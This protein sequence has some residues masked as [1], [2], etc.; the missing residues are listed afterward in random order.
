MGCNMG[1][2]MGRLVIQLNT[3]KI[4]LISLKSL[5]PRAERSLS[6]RNDMSPA[7]ISYPVAIK[8][9]RPDTGEGDA[10]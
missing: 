4:L 8:L 2:D 10:N 1:F 7:G 6:V 9:C 3:E 5:V